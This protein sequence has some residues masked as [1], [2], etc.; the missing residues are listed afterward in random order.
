MFI[1]GS[2]PFK[3]DPRGPQRPQCAWFLYRVKVELIIVHLFIPL[4]AN[5]KYWLI[6]Y[7]A[8]ENKN[9][10]FIV[11]CLRLVSLKYSFLKFLRRGPRS[12]QARQDIV[13]FFA[14]N[15]MLLNPKRDFTRTYSYCLT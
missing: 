3:V 6:S 2:P 9:I 14:E 13:N 10:S 5:P 7:I 11:F 12:A 8:K 4:K 1:S 15:S